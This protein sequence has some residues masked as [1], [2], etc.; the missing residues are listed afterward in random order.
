MASYMR[1]RQICL[2]APHLE[3]VVGD[4]AD[5][6]GLNVC[7]RDPGVGKYGLENM[8]MPLGPSFLEV[9]APSVAYGVGSGVEAPLPLST[10]AAAKASFDC[11][12]GSVQCSAIGP[13]AP[14]AS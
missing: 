2:V 9:V 13:I 5:I 7:Y 12:A 8:L 10:A 3:P 11:D 6:M 1:L 14:Y 4:I